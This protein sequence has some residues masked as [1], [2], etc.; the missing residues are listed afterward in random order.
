[1]TFEQSIQV[2]LIFNHACDCVCHH[3]VRHAPPKSTVTPRS[4][5]IEF[6]AFGQLVAPQVYVSRD[7]LIV[8]MTHLLPGSAVEVRNR[9][10]GIGREHGPGGIR[11]EIGDLTRQLEASTGAA[12]LVFLDDA[13]QRLGVRPG[14]R[15]SSAS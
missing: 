7:P 13:L 2:L 8:R 4:P 1:M 11:V 3:P 10:R 12:E 14:D 15:S 5:N 9:S 6:A